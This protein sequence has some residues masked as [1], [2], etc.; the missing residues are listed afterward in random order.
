MS[1]RKPT[2]LVGPWFGQ[3]LASSLGTS[4]GLTMS[5]FASGVRD[6]EVT[7]PAEVTEEVEMEVA[8]EHSH[9]LEIAVDS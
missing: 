3:W 8:V 1:F 5:S 2:S 7:E 6:A 4:S 9:D